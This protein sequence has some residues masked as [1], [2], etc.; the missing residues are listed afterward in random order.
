MQFD[1]R[2]LKWVKR[3]MGT[4]K[5]IDTTSE[6]I[7]EFGICG[8][9]SMKT[10]GFPEKVAWLKE[11]FREG[12]KIK[13]LYHERDGAQGM[14]E[15]LPGEYCWRPVQAQGYLFIHCLFVGFKR[16]HKS[17]GYASLLLDECEKDARSENRH[18]VAVVTRESAFMVGKGIFLKRG[19]EV[20]DHAPPDFELLV[21]KFAETAPAPK[22]TGN[23]DNKLSRYGK[24]LTI[25]RADQCPY[26]V[27]NVSEIRDSAERLYG[28]KP[29][30]IDL[31]NCAEA[32]NAPCAFGTFCIIFNGEIIADHPISNRRFTNIM[33]KILGRSSGAGRR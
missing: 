23:W 17:K 32:Q 22:F 20:V 14:I 31:Q 13:T 8:Y 29:E 18:G 33:D 5:I 15:Y 19:F 21:K 3:V 2:P 30:V 1:M 12:M 6:N 16:V 4:I 27:K 25:I 7:L 26:T 10:P 11:R 24:G 9:K 28:I